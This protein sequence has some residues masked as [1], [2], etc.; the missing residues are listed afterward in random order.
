[1]QP[2]KEARTTHQMLEKLVIEL[3]SENRARFHLIASLARRCVSQCVMGRRRPHGGLGAS[4]SPPLGPV[5]VGA[6]PSRGLSRSRQPLVG[7]YMPHGGGS[8]V[9]VAGLRPKV[10]GLFKDGGYIV[11]LAGLSSSWWV[12]RRAGGSIVEL[13]GLSSNWRVYPRTGG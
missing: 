2:Q 8:V 6:A 3:E 4:D 10:A 1:M 12:Y 11:E 7:G 5:A 13:A 9:K